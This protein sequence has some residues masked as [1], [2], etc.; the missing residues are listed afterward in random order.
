MSF[1][2]KPRTLWAERAKEG[3]LSTVSLSDVHTHLKRLASA[4]QPTDHLRP[5]RDALV[6]FENR[7]MTVTLPNTDPMLVLDGAA[8]QMAGDVLPSRFFTGLKELAGK[9]SEGERLAAEVWNK[10]ARSKTEPRRIRMV[11]ARIQGEVRPVVRACVSSTYGI[12]SHLEF[13][14][15]ILNHAGEYARLP[16]LDWV[17]TDAG[18]RVRFAGMDAA[19]AAFAPWDESVLEDASIPMV[20]LRNSE[21]GLGSVGLHGGMWRLKNACGIGHWEKDSAWTWYHRGDSARIRAKIVRAFEETRAIA[22]DVVFAYEH[23][24]TI[25]IDDPHT[26]TRMACASLL[27]AEETEEVIKLLTDPRVGNHGTLASVVDA[28]A[29]MSARRAPVQMGVAPE[30]GAPEPDLQDQQNLEKKTA[31]LL[32]RGRTIAEKNGGKIQ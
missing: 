14:E 12:Y 20:E 23:A 2:I 24:K 1:T 16:V 9:D 31:L 29:L 30:K 26:W 17:I 10:F 8:S 28:M 6:R 11:R 32:H 22:Q 27:T 7:R 3:V 18:L 4:Q 5:L 15:D 13:V 25:E 21:V 19:T